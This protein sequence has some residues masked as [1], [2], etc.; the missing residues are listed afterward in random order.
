MSKIILEFFKTIEQLDKFISELPEGSL[1]KIIKDKLCIFT[2]VKMMTYNHK[3]IQLDAGKLAK[4]IPMV[5]ERSKELPL[6][7]KKKHRH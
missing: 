4:V 7:K 5:T 3:F 1:T 6:E 2:G